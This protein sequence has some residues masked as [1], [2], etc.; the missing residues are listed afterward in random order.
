[1][2]VQIGMIRKLGARVRPGFTLIELLIIVL[3]AGVLAALAAPPITSY[4]ESRNRLQARDAFMMMASRARSAA[5]EEGDFVLMTVSATGDSVVVTSQR[6]A[7]AIEVLRLYDGR[8]R[9]DITGSSDITICYTPRGFAHP[10]C[11]DGD[12]LPH[13]VGFASGSDTAYAT[14]TLGRVEPR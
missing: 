1:M 14:I 6:D 7:S 11:R 3:I 5:V 8:G 12:D 4:L 2:D 13:Q 10:S 9:A